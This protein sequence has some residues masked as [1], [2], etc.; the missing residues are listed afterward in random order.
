MT[1]TA[2]DST[3]ITTDTA[4]KEHTTMSVRRIAAA[5]TLVALAVAVPT[6]PAQA[7]PADDPAR[8]E[9][10][11]QSAL[12]AQVRA[13]TARF[14]DVD[15]AIAEGYVDTHECSASADGAM[16][17]HFVNPALIAPGAP[18]DPT[19]PPVLMYGPSASGDLELWGV[20]FFEPDVGQPTPV[21]GTVAFD[22]PMPG[23]DPEM[24]VHYDLH[25]WTGKHNPSGLYA[26]FNP[27]LSC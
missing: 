17:I 6:L 24:P 4:S 15:V 11:S 8:P 9:H 27:S 16:G 20:E 7:A 2:R 23:H 3:T 18:V 1:R 14:H 22:G 5:S 26:P 13:A 25:V 10:A 21:F 12:V 19:R